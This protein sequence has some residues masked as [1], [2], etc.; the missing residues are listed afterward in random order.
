MTIKVNSVEHAQPTPEFIRAL[1]SLKG[2]TFR[3]DFMLYKFR[4][5]QRLRPGRLHYKPKSMILLLKILISSA[6][7]Q[8]LLC[9]M[10]LPAKQLGM[11]RFG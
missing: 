10:I 6:V 3:S 11:G 7:M 5:Q 8:S 9:Y 4:L 1:D 2:H